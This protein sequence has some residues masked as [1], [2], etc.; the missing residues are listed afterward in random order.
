MESRT[1]WPDRFDAWAV[2]LLVAGCIAGLSILIARLPFVEP[3]P[4]CV[5]D[6][7]ERIHELEGRLLEQ[8]APSIEQRYR[9]L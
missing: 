8:V 2:A 6:M 7:R 3:E 9:D 1:P 5:R 4:Q